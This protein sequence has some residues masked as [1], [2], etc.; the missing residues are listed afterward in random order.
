M[1][2]DNSDDQ[3][4]VCSPLEG[5]KNGCDKL[6]MGRSLMKGDIKENLGQVLASLKI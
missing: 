6:I 4:R 2:N 1:P 3:R 5:I